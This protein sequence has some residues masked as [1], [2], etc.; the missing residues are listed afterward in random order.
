MRWFSA[1]SV[2]QNNPEDFAMA[3]SPHRDLGSVG[4]GQASTS[5]QVPSVVLMCCQRE[6]LCADSK[7]NWGSNGE[8]VIQAPILRFLCLPGHLKALVLAWEVQEASLVVRGKDTKRRDMCECVCARACQ[9][10]REREHMMLL[11]SGKGPQ[12]HGSEQGLGRVG[13]I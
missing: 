3:W 11:L 13:R 12:R 9:R 10:E 8:A 2:P 1:F 7:P 6:H 5:V 4:Q